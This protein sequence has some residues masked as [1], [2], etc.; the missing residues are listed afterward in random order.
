MDPAAKASVKMEEAAPA[1]MGGDDQWPAALCADLAWWPVAEMADAKAASTMAEAVAAMVLVA[2]AAVAARR[3]RQNGLIAVGSA[4][5]STST[6]GL[7]PA[8]S[9]G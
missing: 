2:A 8:R 9:C 4:R 6:E 3:R 7:R 5:S 1:A